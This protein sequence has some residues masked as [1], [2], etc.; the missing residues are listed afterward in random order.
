MS[1]Y[2]NLLQA[3]FGQQ[4]P[5]CTV[6]RFDIAKLRIEVGTLVLLEVIA[7]ASQRAGIL[8]LTHAHE[9]A[10]LFTL[11]I[12]CCAKKISL[13]K[14]VTGLSCNESI[15]CSTLQTFQ[16]VGIIT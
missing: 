14:R 11:S 4:S 7:I 8:Q 12:Y 5:E 9:N 1:M 15:G 2:K 16:M 6:Q 10:V 3:V 13:R